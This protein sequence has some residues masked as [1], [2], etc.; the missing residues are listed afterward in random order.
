MHEFRLLDLPSELLE[1]V[2][3]M[4]EIV[5]RV[6]VNVALGHASIVNTTRTNT[7]RDSELATVHM[8]FKRQARGLASVFNCTDISTVMSNFITMNLDDPTIHR[9]VNE[10]PQLSAMTCPPCVTAETIHRMIARNEIVWADVRPEATTDVLRILTSTASPTLFD[11]I[12]SVDNHVRTSVIR[13][14]DFFVFGL[15]NTG[16]HGFTLLRYVMALPDDNAF[17]FPVSTVRTYMS[18]YSIVSI[19]LKR[20]AQLKAIIQWVGIDSSTKDALI[21]E[22]ARRFYVPSVFFLLREGAR[23]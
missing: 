23:L 1:R 2:Y 22:A 9:V 14:A 8:F 13:Q 5:D 6:K 3:D 18:S 10:F 4:L 19:F 21:L 12:M 20:P 17:G 7:Q 16:S 15:V 11:S